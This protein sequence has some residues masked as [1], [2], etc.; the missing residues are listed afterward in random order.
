MCCH[1]FFNWNPASKIILVVILLIEAQKTITYV[2]KD[3]LSH[4]FSLYIHYELP[5]LKIIARQGDCF[6]TDTS[7]KWKVKNG[8]IIINYRA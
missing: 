6:T 2:S 8:V 3:F 7:D 4:W 1:Q 5:T